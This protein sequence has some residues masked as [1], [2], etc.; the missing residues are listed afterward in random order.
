M[1]IVGGMVLWTGDGQVPAEVYQARDDALAARDATQ[2][3]Y[4]GNLGAL[5][6][7]AAARTN[8]GLG[9]LAVQMAAAVAITGGTITGLGSGPINRLPRRGGS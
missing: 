9:S 7:K 4:A 6:D 1:S 5:T 2:A 8:L 3:L